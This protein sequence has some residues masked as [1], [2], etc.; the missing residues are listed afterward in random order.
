MWSSDRCTILLLWWCPILAVSGSVCLTTSLLLTDAGRVGE[1]QWVRNESALVGDSM[2]ECDVRLVFLVDTCEI[3][4]GVVNNSCWLSDFAAQC[5]AT[6][7]VA[8]FMQA[9]VGVSCVVGHV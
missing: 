1:A 2:R 3:Q 9:C 5:G 8:V 4:G 6:R 7:A